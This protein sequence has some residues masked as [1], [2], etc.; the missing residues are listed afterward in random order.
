MSS[1]DS[2]SSQPPSIYW[3]GQNGLAG[4]PRVHSA[5]SRASRASDVRIVVAARQPR[6][7]RK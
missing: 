2:M 6:I 4:W 7:R 5:C 1:T 3:N